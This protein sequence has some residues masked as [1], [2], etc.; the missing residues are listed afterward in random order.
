MEQY[1]DSPSGTHNPC[2]SKTGDD[3][4]DTIHVIT[5]SWA[6]SS[7]LKNDS[8]TIYNVCNSNKNCS[9]YSKA[10]LDFG[11]RLKYEDDEITHDAII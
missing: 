5:S 3:S 4:L 10:A 11:L 8:L 7:I 6:F 2:K 9:V 1:I